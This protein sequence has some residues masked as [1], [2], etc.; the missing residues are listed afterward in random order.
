MLGISLNAM[1]SDAINAYFGT[2]V[3]TFSEILIR[4]GS[5]SSGLLGAIM[6]AVFG[7]ILLFEHSLGSRF[8]RI[9]ISFI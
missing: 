4:C 6:Q 3:C 1:G 5:S 2:E 8:E 9:T 7:L